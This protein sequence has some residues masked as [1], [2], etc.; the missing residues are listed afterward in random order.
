[1]KESRWYEIDGETAYVYDAPECRYSQSVSIVSVAA[2][3]YY[4][5][6]FRLRKVTSA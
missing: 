3:D 5:Q 6:N 1:M 2:L 4:R